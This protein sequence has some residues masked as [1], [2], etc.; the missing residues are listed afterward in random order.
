MTGDPTPGSRGGHQDSVLIVVGG[1]NGCG[2]T[3]FALRYSTVVGLRYLSADSIAERLNPADPLAVAVKA[4]RLF[5]AEL[6]AA[7]NR[8]ESLIV[9]STLSG[10]SLRKS[11]QIA[12]DQDY[13]IKVVFVY[14]EATE[15]CVARVKE[16]V[17]KGGHDVPAPDIARRFGRS[18]RNF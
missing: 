9:E 6:L 15:S 10:L 4:G 18:F 11:F 5:S 7:L 8:G 2:K 13:R 16:R 3:T 1:P 12:R 17:A 14:L